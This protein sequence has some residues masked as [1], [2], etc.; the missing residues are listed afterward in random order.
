MALVFLLV[1]MLLAVD[2][3]RGLVSLGGV[4]ARADLSAVVPGARAAFLVRSSSRRRQRP[5]AFTRPGTSG[6]NGS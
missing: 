5:G 6:R 4:A 3:Y 1:V 2:L